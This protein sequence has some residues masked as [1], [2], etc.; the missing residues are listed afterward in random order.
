MSGIGAALLLLI[1][2]S[3]F[4]WLGLVALIEVGVEHD[5]YDYSGL[6]LYCLGKTG[7]L[8]VDFSI[9]L[10]SAGALMSYIVVVGTLGTELTTRWGWIDRSY[11]LYIVTVMLLGLFALP[12]CCRKHFGHLALIIRPS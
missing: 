12:N 8:F 2:A 3:A 9:A 11:E 6:G 7:E 1:F 10:Y 4:T 5:V